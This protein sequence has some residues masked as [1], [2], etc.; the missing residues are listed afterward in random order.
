M[1]EDP[2]ATARRLI[3][4]QRKYYDLRAPDYA[5]P[6]A[7]A[8]RV[9]PGE[10]PPELVRELIDVLQPTG[11]VL[12]L[13]CGTGIFTG[14][15]VRHA[16]SLTAVDASQAM[17][18]RN[19]GSVGAGVSRVCADVFTWEPTDTY[20]L[21]FFGFWLSHVPPTLFPSFWRTVQSCLRPNGRAAFIDEDMRAV[22]KEREHFEDGV[23]AA[24]RRLRDG[25]SFD[26]VKVFWETRALQERLRDLGW[27]AEVRP[28]GDSFYF[29]TA[30][31]S[32]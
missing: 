21:V 15:L 24:R 25:R 18:Q 27:R 7:P 5:N 29:G 28:V 32:V 13:A 6:D 14:E 12:E 20:D 8:D 3:E 11:D 22:E 23:P 26:I 31:P 10:M 19:E 9:R 17:L 4:S 30:R 1:S 16:S 2:E